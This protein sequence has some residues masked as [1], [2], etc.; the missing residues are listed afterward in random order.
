MEFGNCLA[1]FGE[2]CGCCLDQQEPFAGFFHFALPAVDGCDLGHDVDAG[3]Q[4]M[5]YEVTRDLAGLFFGAGGGQDDSFVGHINSDV[6]G[7][8]ATKEM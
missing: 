5:L 4:A 1:H 6:G 3:C 2:G 8:P 7:S